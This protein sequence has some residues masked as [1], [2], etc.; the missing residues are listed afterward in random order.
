MNL[1]L[2]FLEPFNE[3]VFGEHTTYTLDL[4]IDDKRRGSH[5]TLLADFLDVGDML[6]VC[7]KTH[8]GHYLYQF[9]SSLSHWVHPGPRTLISVP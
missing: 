9:L 4:A 2:G 6:N 1:F 3:F 7:R 8:L 5:H